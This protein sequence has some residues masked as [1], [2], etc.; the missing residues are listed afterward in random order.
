MIAG[1]DKIKNI[2][3]DVGGVLIDYRWKEY[4]MDYGYDAKRAETVGL[5]ILEDPIWRQ[6][7]KGE[8]SEDEV[9][10]YYRKKLPWEN[11]FIDYFFANCQQM[12]VKREKLYPVIEKLF[13]KGYNIYILSNYSLRLF[14]I[15]TA[16][17]SFFDKCKGIVVSQNINMLKPDA[18]IYE[19]ILNE[20]NLIPD[21]CIFFDDNE[22]NVLGGN[23]AGISSYC[24]KTE[25]DLINYLTELI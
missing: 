7:D 24:V 4:I 22:E 12:M 14:N 11:D 10:S 8:I 1:S 16:H 20:Y 15:H 3:F 21:T 23:K 9:I 18:E 19:Y 25:A 2:I 13:T 17:L 5:S 6:M